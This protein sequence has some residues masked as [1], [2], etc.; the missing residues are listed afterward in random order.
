MMGMAP[1][2]GAPGAPSMDK[3]QADSPHEHAPDFKVPV[4]LVH[5]D[6]DYVVTVDQSKAMDAALTAAHKPHEFVLLTGAD[7]EISAEDDRTKEF[8]ALESFLATN[9]H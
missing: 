4:L 9:L 7:H 2:G 3:L 5:G 8:T 6:H 1:P